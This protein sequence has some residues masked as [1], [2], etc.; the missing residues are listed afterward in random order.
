M[1]ELPRWLDAVD[2][3]LVINIR[4][5]AITLLLLFASASAAHAGEVQ[6]IAHPSV[7]VQQLTKLELRRIFSRKQTLWE[8]GLPIVVYVLPSKD[9]LHQ[10][11]SKEVLRIF[12]YQLDRI[13]NKLTYSGIGTAPVIVNSYQAMHD[14]I[15]TTPGAI[16]YSEN[17][18]K[19]GNIHVINIKE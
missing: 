12:P 9:K 4:A 18:E 17:M 5:L 19:G 13:W 10:R 7:N 16:G 15:S 14:A 3:E 1:I 11:F 2:R 6:T 8:N